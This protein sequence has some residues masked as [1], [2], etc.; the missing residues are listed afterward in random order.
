MGDLPEEGL[1]ACQP[2]GPG[3]TDRVGL[4]PAADAGRAGFDREPYARRPPPRSAFGPVGPPPQGGWGIARRSPEN[5]IGRPR[6]AVR[7]A[8]AAPP[9]SLCTGFAFRRPVS[10]RQRPTR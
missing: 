7:P 6:E 4:A 10:G 1:K 9:R 5:P 8:P 3:L 2:Q